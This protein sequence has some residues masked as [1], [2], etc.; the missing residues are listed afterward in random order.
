MPTKLW[1]IKSLGNNKI[2]SNFVQSF[3][4]YS[5]IFGGCIYKIWS[6]F[7]S[8]KR[9]QGLFR[10]TLVYYSKSC[11]SMNNARLWMLRWSNYDGSAHL[12]VLIGDY[13]R[14]KSEDS[15]W[16]YQWCNQYNNLVMIKGSMKYEGKSIHLLPV[17]R[18]CSSCR[19]VVTFD[20]QS[21]KVDRVTL[22]KVIRLNFF[23]QGR[24]R[25]AAE[26]STVSWFRG[27]DT[28][29]IQWHRRLFTEFK[30]VDA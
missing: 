11:L 14:T 23:D 7:H 8:K 4:T 6:I 28:L 19:Q 10:A 29:R 16:M 27:L 26:S 21:N 20:I 12:L 3:S 18:N 2:R 1:A 17:L 15:I 5:R 25:R 30:K 24:P 9:I 22:S 13:K